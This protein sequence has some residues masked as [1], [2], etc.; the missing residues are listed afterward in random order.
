[1]TFV[2]NPPEI[3]SASN[4]KPPC[5][6]HGP[7]ILLRDLHNPSHYYYSCSASRDLQFCSYK[8]SAIKWRKKS[9]DSQSHPCQSNQTECLALKYK[10]FGFCEECSKLLVLTDSVDTVPSDHLYSHHRQCENVIKSIDRETLKRPS[11]LLKPIIKN[12]SLAQYHFSEETINFLFEYVIE[13][14]K[15]NQFICIGCPTLFE[16]INIKYPGNVSLL[17][18]IDHRFRQF[19]SIEQFLQFNMFNGYFFETFGEKILS[20]KF[21]I[22]EKILILIDPPFGGLIECLANSLQQI[23]R[24][25]LNDH[26]IHWALFFPYFNEHWI[27]RTFVEQKFKPADFMVTYRNHTKFASHKKHQSP[28]RIFTDLNLLNFVGI[29]P[30]NYKWCSECSRT[31]FANN[32]HC[33]ECDDC[34]GRDATKG[35]RHCTRCDRCVKSTW[36][37]CEKCSTCHHYNNCNFKFKKLKSNKR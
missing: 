3:F 33:F 26:Q 34:P 5:C 27:T 14:F 10:N 1:M 22:G 9:I 18:D 12:K 6:S 16:E 30:A 23:T 17:M 2:A 11:H 15:F 8:L 32:R 28:I 13:K 21:K 31:T 29:D 37:H 24:N 25:Y 20:N 7:T 19:Y 4:L 36:N 35:L